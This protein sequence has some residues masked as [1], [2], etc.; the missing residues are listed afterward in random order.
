MN[1]LHPVRNE[2]LVFEDARSRALLE[3]L[4]Q[5]AASDAHTLIRGEPGTGKKQLARHLHELSRRARAPFFA[6][7]CGASSAEQLERHMHGHERGAFRGAFAAAPG[8][9]ELAQNGTLFLDEVDALP[10]DLQDRLLAL[11]DAAQVSRQGGSSRALPIDVRLVAATGVDLTL[12]VSQGRFRATLCERL[13][14][15]ELHLPTLSQRPADILPLARRFIALQSRRLNHPETSL[16]Q[17]AIGLLQAHD[18]PGHIRE[19]ENV[20]HHAMLSCEDGVI[21]VN[22]IPLRPGAALQE[23]P[24]AS[25]LEELEAAL[26]RLCEAM[27]GRLFEAVERSLVRTAYAHSQ[28]NQVKAAELLGVSRNVLRGRLIEYGEIQALK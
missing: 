4:Q 5:V 1:A 16:D 12:A 6:V 24:S 21:R 28:H 27:P 3:R 9:F 19:L 23:P 10:L 17:A 14:A 15:A 26:Q 25:P 2:A 22:D 20:I 7:H 8:W 18:W 13:G 11:L